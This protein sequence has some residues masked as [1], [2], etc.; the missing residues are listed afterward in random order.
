MRL[1]INSNSPYYSISENEKNIDLIKEKDMKI[2][3]E[4]KGFIISLFKYNF[5]F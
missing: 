2:F 3:T 1:N 4:I 5:A